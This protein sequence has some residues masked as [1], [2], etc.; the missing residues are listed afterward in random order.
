MNHLFSANKHS[1]YP[2]SRYLLKSL[3][4]IL[5]AAFCLAGSAF[6][7]GSNT[8]SLAWD[9]NPEAD[10]AG[11]R[12]QYGTTP[13]SYTSSMD[14]GVT[15]SATATGLHQGTT[16]YFTV[17]AYNAAG[18]TSAP[19]SEVTYTVP[20][21]P[22][23][24]PSAGSFSLSLVEDGQAS[25][26]L[27]GTDA[28]GDT[29]SYAI[30]AGPSK[31][32]L[33]GTAPNLTYR[34][35]ANANGSD[36]FT[37]R[38]SDGALDSGIATVSIEITPVNDP[39]VAGAKSLTVPE[40][41]QVAITLTGTDVDGD[42]LRYEIVSEPTK[43]ALSGTPPN[44]TY[45]P[46]ANV[47]GSDSFSYRVSDGSATS[48]PAMV[49]IT[50]SP[51]NDA[52]VA[53]GQSLTVAEDTPLS[54]R[55]TGT[56][57]EGSSLTYT[58]VSQP[59]SGTL[60]G[61]APN[62]TYTPATNF[63][64]TVSFT[65]RV[66]D[67]TANSANATVSITVTPVNDAPVA[68]PRT[69]T[70][71]P[72]NP[73]A[74]VLAGT[75]VEGSPLTFAIVT[76]PANGS[77][78]GTAP[79][80]TYTPRSGFTGS[81][82]FTYRA[83]DGALNS[84]V[85]TVSI[86]V[87]DTNRAPQAYGKFVTMMKNKSA[88]VTLS[89]ADADAD[90]LTFR[91]VTPPANGTLTGTAPNFTYTPAAKWVGEDTLTYVV[92]DGKVDSA[93]ATV[94]LKV[95]AKN[96]KPVAT[97]RTASANQNTAAQIVVAGSDPDGDNLSFSVVKQPANG[98]V[99]GT[100]PNFIYT[101]KS[102]FK[103]TDRFTFIATDGTAKSAAALVEITVTNPNNRAPVAQ[104]QGFSGPA[105]KP[106]A[107]TLRGTDADNDPLTFRVVSPVTGGKL[108]GKGANLKFKPAANFTGTIFFNYVANDGTVDSAPGTIM[109][110]INPPVAA[111]R[112]ATAK[113][114]EPAQVP[115]LAI[116]RNATGGLVLAVTGVPGISYMVEHSGDL[117]AWTDFREVTIS[118]S[119][120]TEVA[121]E[122]PADAK[123]G[124]FRLR[125]PD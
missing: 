73:V 5:V 14:A 65:F 56:D 35:A 94:R 98:T 124:Y 41:G 6:S 99:T 33:S 10:I 101:P 3:A 21:L 62:L 26:T 7:A 88:V 92:N 95:K 85:A 13:G 87:T 47:N 2:P 107:L 34:P 29:L 79:N 46:A 100:G 60:S 67:G 96:T 121:L 112:S 32:T 58:V 83:N 78:G 80:L 118:A 36:S 24:A 125:I 49:N 22:N 81:D 111:A 69:L 8:V 102:G 97:A 64:G 57:I 61:T 37:Y 106:V 38:V 116:Q 90:A 70:T 31:G 76:P 30:V 39:P 52:P 27:S 113:L 117:A 12:L 123:S 20:G 18:Q 75:D 48:A 103:G 43:G 28:E 17:V 63:N 89:G 45:R 50:I 68:V 104:S 91:I 25:V 11:Y 93:S 74:V 4:A 19:S 84:A 114:A 82:S 120:V 71:T 105:K 59:G 54:I 86:S 55:L 109:V 40:D 108:I 77:L 122:I 72:G 66:S 44:L 23:T 51:V 42:S 1:E 110:V 115:A 15:T 119:G 53:N 9:R 16:Y